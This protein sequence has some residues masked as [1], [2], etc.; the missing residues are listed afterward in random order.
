MIKEKPP[1]K[2]TWSKLYKWNSRK[3]ELQYNIDH[4]NYKE[5]NKAGH[6][7]A[8]GYGKV[9]YKGRK[10]TTRRIIW[11]MFYGPVPEGYD[12]GSVSPYHH[13]DCPEKLFLWSKKD[14]IGHI[15]TP[16]RKSY[17]KFYIGEYKE[18]T[19]ERTKMRQILGLI[20]KE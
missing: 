9:C 13:D 1:G 14:Q 8:L 6:N 11:E 2:E 20:S 5:G 15:P 10:Y 4:A 3:G 7:T 16:D 17:R 19:K 12:T 18:I